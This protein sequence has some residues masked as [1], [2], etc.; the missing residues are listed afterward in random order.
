[1]FILMKGDKVTYVQYVCYVIKKGANMSVKKK[2]KIK[3]M[4]VYTHAILYVMVKIST[5]TVDQL[6]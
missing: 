1:M 6:V 2:K 3:D 4:Q 5:V